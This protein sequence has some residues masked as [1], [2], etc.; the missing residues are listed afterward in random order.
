MILN[1]RISARFRL[2]SLIVLVLTM[3]FGFIACQNSEQNNTDGTREAKSKIVFANED[4]AKI[5]VAEQLEKPIPPDYKIPAYITSGLPLTQVYDT[6]KMR[7]PN[8]YGKEREEYLHTQ[9][10][11]RPQNR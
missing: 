2:Q 6:L 1:L 10:R 4:E 3:M 5:F 8:F 11:R 7:S 9:S